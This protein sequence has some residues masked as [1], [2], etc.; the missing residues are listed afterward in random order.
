MADLSGHIDYANQACYELFGY[1][2]DEADMEGKLMFSLWPEDA[3]PLL[4]GEVLPSAGDSGW[5]GEVLQVRKDKTTFDASLTCFSVKSETGQPICIAAIIRDITE[6]KKVQIE[7]QR[8]AVQL[9][10][11][12]RVS[13]QVNSI[14]DPTQL[15]EEVVPLVQTRFDLYHVHVYTFDDSGENLVMRV[16]S[17]EPG[18]LMRERGHQ[19]T[20]NRQHSLVAK[21]ARTQEIIKVDDVTKEIDFLPNA[22]LPNTRSELAI[23][24]IVAG[25]VVGI[26]DVQ[27]DKPYRFSASEVDVLSTLAAQTATSFRNARSFAEIQLAAEHL[28]EVDRLKSEFLGNMS[29]ELRTPL[30]SILGY[31]EVMLMGIDGDLPDMMKEDVEA[32]YNNGQQLLS[33]INDIL[34]LTKIEAGRMMLNFQPVPLVPLL[35]SSKTNNMGMLLK[36]KVPVDIVISVEQDLPPI[37]ADRVRMAQI[38]NNLVSNAIKFTDEGT[39]TISAQY[40]EADDHVQIKVKDTGVGIAPEDLSKLFHRFRQVDGSSTRRAEGTGL[41]LAITKHLVELHRGKLNVESTLNKGSTFT[42]SIPVYKT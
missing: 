9:S 15:L 4:L 23:P 16:G 19:I 17:G 12:A 11:A 41:G 31:A 33:L 30:N 26:F 2:V 38:L 1:D 25:Q 34:D 39:I 42:V 36:R 6:R 7:L 28:R 22:L 40:N 21:A 8:F 13:T 10:T 35:E 20:L 3:M 32:I 18:K 37:N 14:L 24:M 27:D 29:H 5:Q